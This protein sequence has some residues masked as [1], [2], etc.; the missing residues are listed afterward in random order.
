MTYVWPLCHPVAE[1]RR[2]V[3]DRACHD[4]E[5]GR[6]SSQG[7]WRCADGENGKNNVVARASLMHGG[8][9]GLWPGPE[10]I[11]KGGSVPRARGRRGE[12]SLGLRK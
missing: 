2:S 7:R 9:R 10:R 5:E 11:E 12:V 8:I 1:S 6:H 4:P 3:V